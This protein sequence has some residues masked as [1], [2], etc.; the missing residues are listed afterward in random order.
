[1]AIGLE[2]IQVQFQPILDAYVMG[3]I[4]EEEMLQG[5]QWE[6]RWTWSYEN[7]RPIFQSEYSLHSIKH[8]VYLDLFLIWVIL[9]TLKSG[10][11]IKDF[12]CSFECQF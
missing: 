11:R 9:M 1:M 3:D 8:H 5:V 6:K 2:Q 7:Y 4:S 10:E 12:A